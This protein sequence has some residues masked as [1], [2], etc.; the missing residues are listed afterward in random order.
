LETKTHESPHTVAPPTSLPDST[1]PTLVP[2]L[3]RTARMVVHVSPAMSLGLYASIAEV[4]GGG[5]RDR[6]EFDSDSKSEDAEDEGP[7]LEDEDPVA[8]DEGPGTRVKSLGLGGDAVLPEGQQRT[9]SVIETTVGQSYRSVPEPEIPERVSAL[10]QPTLTT[11][12]DLDDDIAYIDVPT[13]PPP[14]PPAQTPPSY[15]WSSGSLS[16]SPTLSIVPSPFITHDTTDRSITCS[17]TRYAEAEEFLTE[18]GARVEMQGGLIHGH[19]VRLEELS[20][21]LFERYDKDME[22]LFTRS[23]E[24][25]DEIF[26]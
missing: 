21:A 26:S 25:R 19:K 13:Y 18:L 11:W 15:E 24:V 1:P 10:R 6:E 4:A 14:A 20:P 9:A 3:F 5:R 16:V 2:I 7:T 8:W 23:G 22:E 12:I 17:F